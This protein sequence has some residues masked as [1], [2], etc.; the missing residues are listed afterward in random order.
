MSTHCLPN[1]FLGASELPVPN[2][3]GPTITVTPATGGLRRGIVVFNHGLITAAQAIAAP[4]TVTDFFSAFGSAYSLSLASNLAADGWT[5]LSIAAQE[6]G[7]AGVPSL[8]VVADVNADSGNGAR[9]LASTLHTWDHVWQYIQAT[10]GNVPIIAGG[11]SMGAWRTLQIVANR[12]SQVAGF[13]AIQPATVFENVATGYTPGAQFYNS[14]FSGMDLGPTFLNVIG[15]VPGIINTSISDTATYSGGY[16]LATSTAAVG[17][18]M[19]LTVATSGTNVSTNY[20]TTGGYITLTGLTGGTGQAVLSYTGYAAGSFSG[21]TV[22]SGSGTPNAS[23]VV[24][25]SSIDSIIA[26]AVTAGRSITR[27]STTQPHSL[28]LTD[29]GAY[30]TG[31]TGT[32]LSALTSS[33]PISAAQASTA[34][35]GVQSLVPGSMAVQDSTGTWHTILGSLAMSGSAITGSPISYSG[36][37]SA[38]L[39]NGAPICNTGSA[40]TGGFANISIPYWINQNISPSYP[41]YF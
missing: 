3:S 22:L 31:T 29:T 25:Q 23:T 17:N 30:F 39:N 19:T 14:N 38:T 7:F 20:A 26:N 41:R 1:G 11:F 4:P 24:K 6:D 34:F 35:G 12:S 21:I 13:F 9:Y 33:L 15:S 16:S 28:G 8:G 27:A 37:A 2:I 32:A 5:V 40:I 10:Y 36:S 18:G